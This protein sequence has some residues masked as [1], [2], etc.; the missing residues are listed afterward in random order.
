M[1][2]NFQ[3]DK[4]GMIMD[5][6]PIYE[7]L[8][9]WHENN[10]YDKILETIR[11]VPHGM[12]SNKLWFRLISALNNKRVF[13]EAR[14]QLEQI[15]ERCE[16]PEEWGKYH[17]M[18]GYIY[19]I[20]NLEIK[21]L[22][23][24]RNAMKADPKRDLSEDCELCE[25]YIDN[26]LENIRTVVEKIVNDMTERTSKTS[27]EDKI[28]LNDSEFTMMLSFLPAIRRIPQ[29]DKCIGLD[30]LFKKYT[31][32]EKEI[33]K[34]FLWNSYEIKDIESLKDSFRYEFNI[35]SR[36]KDIKAYMQGKA[37]FDVD[38]ELT[39]EGKMAFNACKMFAET[40]SDKIPESG[41][42]A[43]DISERI[44]LLRLAYSCDLLTNSDYVSGVETFTD[45]AKKYF[46][47]W[48]EYLISLLLGAGFYIFSISEFSFKEAFEFM[49]NMALIVLKG[50]APDCKWN[51]D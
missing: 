29:L 11:A 24:Y 35:D 3:L 27:D 51:E 14:E 46:S 9:E 8:D 23:C 7:K 30:S 44:G 31:G 20:E 49:C 26:G 41:F 16:T 17:Y 47:S 12:W 38:K 19:D 13:N 40:I 39:S 28:K 50:D 15:Y 18:L 22:E 33:V 10:E 32:E 36:Y 2:E 1:S 42:L 43:W 48:K 37:K 6:D 5:N 25:Q 45:E 34:D 21:A 4:N